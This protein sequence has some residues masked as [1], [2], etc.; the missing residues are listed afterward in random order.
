ML[1]AEHKYLCALKEIH[2]LVLRQSEMD[3]VWRVDSMTG[4]HPAQAALAKLHN[5]IERFTIPI[6]EKVGLHEVD[7]GK[8]RK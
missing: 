8:K 7:N 1:S 6:F 2:Q 5:T 3:E 4:K